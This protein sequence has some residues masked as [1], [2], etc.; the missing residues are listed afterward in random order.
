MIKFVVALAILALPSLA[1]AS[2][3]KIDSAHSDVGFKVRHLMVSNVKGSFNKYTG[4][5]DLHETDITKSKVDVTIDVNSINTNELKRDEH[6]RSADFFDAAKFPTITFVS[7]KWSSAAN[8]S[9]KVAGNLTIHGITREVV[10]NVEPFSQEIKDPWGNIRRGTSASANINRHDFGL[11]WNKA[12]DA[13]GVMI[14]DEVSIQLEVELVK[15][16]PK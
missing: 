5:V 10:L 15:V 4:I 7:K 12:L 16:Q 6:L 14:G 3:W 2:S 8:G 13:G 1:M 9:L 11:T